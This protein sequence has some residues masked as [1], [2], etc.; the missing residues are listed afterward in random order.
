MS[1]GGGFALVLYYF[2]LLIIVG[3]SWCYRDG[4][5]GF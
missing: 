4:V 5:Y 2:I 3:T 1:Q